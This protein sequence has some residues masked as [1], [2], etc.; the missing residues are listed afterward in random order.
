MPPWLPRHPAA[1]TLACTDWPFCVFGCPKQLYAIS[2]NRRTFST[3]LAVRPQPFCV[4]DSRRNTCPFSPVLH[5]EAEGNLVRLR[6]NL[7]LTDEEREAIDGDVHTF[8]ARAK[9]WDT[10]TPTGPSPHEL[11][12]RV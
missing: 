9:R 11:D 5:S 2:R 8:Q 3:V 7:L 6:Q 10:A 1:Q 12:G 4:Y